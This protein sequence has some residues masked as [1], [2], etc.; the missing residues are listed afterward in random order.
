MPPCGPPAPPAA[1]TSASP[2][3]LRCD[4]DNGQLT[5]LIAVSV[6]GCFIAGSCNYAVAASIL[7]LGGNLGGNRGVFGGNPGFFI[8]S[9]INKI[10]PVLPC[11]PAP[12]G[13]NPGRSAS[14]LSGSD[15]AQPPRNVGSK[16]WSLFPDIG[17]APMVAGHKPLCRTP[18]RGNKRRKVIAGASPATESS[19]RASRSETRRGQSERAVQ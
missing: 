12:A 5:D 3:S 6:S 7:I 9:N 1:G 14:H 10:N 19:S 11:A 17:F 2:F 4:P 13:S 8:K 15:G 16:A 18:P